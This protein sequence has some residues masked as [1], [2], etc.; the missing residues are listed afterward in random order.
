MLCR[1]YRALLLVIYCCLA[2]VAGPGQQ[3]DTL[4][5]LR[6]PSVTDCTDPYTLKGIVVCSAAPGLSARMTL[7]SLLAG[8]H[9][10]Q[11]QPRR[12]IQSSTAA[13]AATKESALTER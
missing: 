4:G 12:M 2:I 6:C 3:P 11:L 5:Q 13:A 7:M 8:I 10:S 1:I 9:G